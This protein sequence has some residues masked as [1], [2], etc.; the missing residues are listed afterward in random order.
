[1]RNLKQVG[2]ASIAAALA[3]LLPVSA[4]LATN[5]KGPNPIKAE[6][7]AG[8][9]LA[10]KHQ[11]SKKDPQAAQKA[12]VEASRKAK[13]RKEATGR[14]HQGN[15]DSLTK[16]GPSGGSKGDRHDHGVQQAGAAGGN[17]KKQ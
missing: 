6:L 2:F 7:A 13:D 1:M 5:K 16:A 3:L 9:N 15:H 11:A 4:A 14:D 12:A 10:A 17:S 8:T